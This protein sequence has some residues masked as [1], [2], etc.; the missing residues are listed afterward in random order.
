MS[1]WM[2]A[3]FFSLL[4]F[5][6]PAVAQ[7]IVPSM[8]NCA[9]FD[10]NGITNNCSQSISLQVRTNGREVRRQLKPGE[11]W[12]IKGDYFGAACPLGYVSTIPVVDDNMSAF[13]NNSYECR[14]R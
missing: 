7:Q 1:R 2:T 8:E 9:G 10:D 5:S 11:T 4:A 12:A 6:C 14:K 13:N 3:A